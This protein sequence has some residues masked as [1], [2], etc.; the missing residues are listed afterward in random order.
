LP[1]WEGNNA[2]KRLRIRRGDQRG[3]ALLVVLWTLMLLSLLV[4]AFAQQTRLERQ[5]V[6]NVIAAATAGSDLQA[7]LS[8]GISALLDSKASPAWIHDG[9]PRE[10]EFAGRP[11]SVSIQDANGCVSLNEANV[12]QLQS[13][14]RV[15][16]VESDAGRSLAAAIVD[17][18][19]PDNVI[20]PNGAELATYVENGAATR[21]ANRP[22]FSVGELKSVFGMPP[23]VADKLASLVSVYTAGDQV[24]PMTA[25]E[26]VLRAAFPE[27]EVPEIL[28]RR[29][30]RAEAKSGPEGAVP[31]SDVGDADIRSASD[32][33]LVEVPEGPVYVLEIATLAHQGANARARAVVWL[34]QD[35]KQPYHVLDWQLVRPAPQESASPQ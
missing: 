7:G 29:A 6:S 35:A 27:E 9:S 4:V 28:A 21:P 11:V 14:L 32:K 1:P 26:P 17:W 23:E 25:P 8:L 5:R 31:A 24:N 19:D 12:E 33:D 10:L 2:M 16:G 34:T 13:L 15:V 22:F 30:K 3:I 18:R 20:T